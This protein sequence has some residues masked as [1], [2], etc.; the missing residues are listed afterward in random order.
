MFSFSF[1]EEEK[2][3]FGSYSLSGHPIPSPVYEVL[4]FLV[5]LPVSNEIIHLYN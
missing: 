4:H 1:I 2:K 3:Y 5:L